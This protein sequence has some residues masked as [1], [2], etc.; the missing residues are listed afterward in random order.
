MELLK[1]TTTARHFEKRSAW[2]ANSRVYVDFKGENMM[3]NLMN[4][5]ARPFEALKPLVKK[6]LVELKA[7]GG[8]LELLRTDLKIRW[9]QKAGCNCGCS[10]GFVL[11]ERIV[12]EGTPLDIWVEVSETEDKVGHEIDARMAELGVK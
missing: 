6:A 3:N 12:V 7:Q 8:G 2:V 5:R 10:P 1:V 11:D 9:S 4:R